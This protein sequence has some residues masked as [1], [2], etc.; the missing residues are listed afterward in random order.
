[1]LFQKGLVQ[2]LWLGRFTFLFQ[3]KQEIPE[4]D[5]LSSHWSLN[6]Q[7]DRPNKHTAVVSGTVK[8]VKYKSNLIQSRS[9][10]QAPVGE[11][12]SISREQDWL[13]ES[14]HHIQHRSPPTACLGDVPTKSVELVLGNWKHKSK[15]QIYPAFV[16]AGT[17]LFVPVIITPHQPVNQCLAFAFSSGQWLPVPSHWPLS[18]LLLQPPVAGAANT[19]GFISKG[20]NACH[21]NYVIIVSQV[22]F[23]KRT[24]SR[25]PYRSCFFLQT[26]L[27]RVFVLG[28]TLLMTETTSQVL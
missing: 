27:L 10:M 5:T 22:K 12:I 25:K 6:K 13:L 21:W 17:K 14:L 7:I 23:E 11:H 20:P 28:T 4:A 19:E 16:S 3:Q 8:S 2:H 24:L 1:M 9:K 18:V 15:H 26:Q